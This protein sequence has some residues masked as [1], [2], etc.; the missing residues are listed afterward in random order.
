MFVGLRALRNKSASARS[1]YLGVGRPL[2]VLL[3]SGSELRVNFLQMLIF[4][5]S[6]QPNLAVSSRQRITRSRVTLFSELQLPLKMVSSLRHSRETPRRQGTILASLRR[7]GSGPGTAISTLDG[8]N[9]DFS[10]KAALEQFFE[11]PRRVPDARFE[12]AIWLNA[13][14]VEANRVEEG[15]WKRPRPQIVARTPTRYYN[16]IRRSLA[17]FTP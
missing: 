7:W 4:F 8:V 13:D 6:H 5:R 3:T 16:Y 9:P 2:P 12:L 11:L 14:D 10:K 17:E 15:G 1:I